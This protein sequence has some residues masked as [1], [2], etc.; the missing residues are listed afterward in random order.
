[1]SVGAPGPH[2]VGVVDAFIE[3][4]Q[5]SGRLTFTLAEVAGAVPT[6]GRALE[7]ALRRRAS[8]GMIVRVAPRTG[9]FVIVP[10]E[11]RSMGCPPVDWWLDDLMSFL[12]TSYYVG[13]LSAAALHGS[14]HFA[15]METQVVATKWFRPIHVGRS[16]IRFF[17]RQD[18]GVMPV[19]VR[20][21]DWGPLTVATRETTVVDLLGHKA[22]GV[23]RV[24]LALAEMPGAL[25]RSNLM[26][27]LDGAR[28]APTAQRLGYVLEWVGR[29]REARWVRRWLEGR[30]Y[31]A[32][33]LQPGAPVSPEGPR[34]TPWCVQGDMPEGMLA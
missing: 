6:E 11:H 27:A 10:P 29:D 13:L 21:G 20:Q 7:A 17:Q 4:V 32:V 28:D 14:S 23:D 12:G 2:H 1:M 3:S 8:A 18:T 24:A 30:S 25:D 15:V 16:R 9:F 34:H 31:N 22:C 19:E 26:A 33:P 5:A